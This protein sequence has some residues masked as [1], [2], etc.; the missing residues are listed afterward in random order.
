VKFFKLPI[1]FADPKNV[2]LDELFHACL[3][4]SQQITNM[5]SQVKVLVKEMHQSLPKKPMKEVGIP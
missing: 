2:I 5:L 1:N 3:S 4:F